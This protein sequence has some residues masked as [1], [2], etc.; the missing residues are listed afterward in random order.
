MTVTTSQWERAVAPRW[1]TAAEQRSPV[2]T[3]WSLSPMVADSIPSRPPADT[4]RLVL[5]TYIAIPGSV[6]QVAAA[7]RSPSQ[8]LVA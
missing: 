5:D 8:G 7:Y 4:T 1:V 2:G 3:G 6:N